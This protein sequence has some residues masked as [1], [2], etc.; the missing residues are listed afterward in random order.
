MAKKTRYK[1]LIIT[2][3]ALVPKG[4][5]QEKAVFKGIEFKSLKQLTNIVKDDNNQTMYL[6]WYPLNK[7]DAHGDFVD[8]PAVLEN[9]AIDFMK[10][11]EK[12]IKIL[13]TRGTS[14]TVQLLRSCG[15]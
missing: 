7:V 13:Q 6:I 14:Q 8:S 10:S 3:N 15:L 9:A 4:A 5:V 2:A 11:G 12:S 1:K